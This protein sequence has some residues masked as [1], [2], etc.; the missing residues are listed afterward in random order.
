MAGAVAVLRCIDAEGHR[1]VLMAY[2]GD[3]E[4]WEALSMVG[5]AEID[6][7]AHLARA[8]QIDPIDPVGP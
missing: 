1:R 4:V 5:V 6:V 8:P 7:R 2:A 3:V